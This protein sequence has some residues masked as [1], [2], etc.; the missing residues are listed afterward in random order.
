[1]YEWT[2]IDG[3]QRYLRRICKARYI[4]YY[5]NSVNLALSSV[6]RVDWKYILYQVNKCFYRVTLP[7]F[8]FS[9]TKYRGEVL[10]E[11]PLR[12]HK[13]H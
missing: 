7:P 6:A 3:H 4:V 13:I 2:Y 8:K 5:G 10:A 9:R 11:S 12:G 1:M